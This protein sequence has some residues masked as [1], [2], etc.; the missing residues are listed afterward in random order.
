MNTLVIILLVPVVVL[1]FWE[2][3]VTR[4]DAAGAAA[5]RLGVVMMSCD[6]KADIVIFADLHNAKS[7]TRRRRRKWSI[8]AIPGYDC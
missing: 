1:Q 7:S 5:L 3:G 6:A 2:E 4:F 8:V